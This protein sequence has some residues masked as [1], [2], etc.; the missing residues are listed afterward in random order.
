MHDKLAANLGK[1]VAGNPPRAG[2]KTVPTT[3]DVV[4]ALDFGYWTSLL[5]NDVEPVL[6]AA[7]LFKAFPNAS[8]ARGKAPA[9]SPIAGKLN[10]V[11]MSRNRV[12]HHEPLFNRFNVQNDLRSIVEV[13]RWANPDAGDWIQHHSD[14]TDLL[15]DRFGAQHRF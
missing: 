7:G 1:F 9:Q 3:D 14:L 6:Y 5:N 11:R 8:H 13:C 2:A 12:M 10:E 15:R 4:A